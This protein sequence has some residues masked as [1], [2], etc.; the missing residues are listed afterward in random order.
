MLALT[1][2]YLGSQLFYF[3]QR[4]PEW[5]AKIDTAPVVWLALFV[6]VGSIV[7]ALIPDRTESD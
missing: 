5:A 7:L 6:F 4:A 1:A 2:G 3:T